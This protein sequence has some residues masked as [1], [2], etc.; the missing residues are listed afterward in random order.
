MTNHSQG[1]DKFG[2]INALDGA[3][4]SLTEFRVLI[5]VWR[6]T[7]RQGQHAYAS[8]A[9]LAVECRISERS[10]RRCLVTLAQKRFLR[11]VTRGGRDIGPRASEYALTP[12]PANPFGVGTSESQQ[13]TGGQ[14]GESQQA[15]SRQPTD[16]LTPAN[17]PPDARQE[18]TGVTATELEQNRE[19]N[20][21][22]REGRVHAATYLPDDRSPAPQLVAQMRA[23]QPHVDQDLELK[24]FQDHYRSTDK[25]AKKRDWSAAYRNWVRREAQWSRS[26]HP[27][28]D[29]MTA[30]ERKTA[31]NQ[32]VF[33]SL[34]D[35]P[36]TPELES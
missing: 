35:N 22:Q 36:P 11:R 29:G 34:A 28:Q 4:L 33:Q 7:D 13:A 25:S 24:R 12:I 32:A 8:A 9:R 5:A 1:L 3:D 14:L 23:E 6:H 20:R 2:Y 27:P 18:A 15:K 10:V 30:Y 21:E 31:H 17:W 26:S 16:T 19:Q